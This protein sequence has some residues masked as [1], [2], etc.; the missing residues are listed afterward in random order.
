MQYEGSGC[1][2]L[3]FVLVCV[4]GKWV[5]GN[6]GNEMKHIHLKPKKRRRRRFALPPHSLDRFYF[7]H[8]GGIREP[9]LSPIVP[10][11]SVFTSPPVRLPPLDKPN[12]KDDILKRFNVSIITST[13][14]PIVRRMKSFEFPIDPNV[15]PSP[16][17]TFLSCPENAGVVDCLVVSVLFLGSGG[18]SGG[19]VL[20]HGSGPVASSGGVGRFHGGGLD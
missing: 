8:C 10:A 14:D 17:V 5:K 18:R 12:G 3:W 19:F 9:C 6:D 11:S 20:F 4:D 7:E 2:H 1:Q 13:G 16:S 15:P